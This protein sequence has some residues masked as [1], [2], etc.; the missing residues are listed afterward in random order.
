MDGRSLEPKAYLSRSLCPASLKHDGIGQGGCRGRCRPRPVYAILRSDLVVDDGSTDGTASLVA[1]FGSHR[2]RRIRLLK[3]TDRIKGYGGPAEWALKPPSIQSSLPSPMRIASSTWSDLEPL[4]GPGCRTPH[5]GWLPAKSA[6]LPAARGVSIP[7]ATI[8]LV[9]ALAGH[10]RTR[11]RLRALKVFRRDDVLSGLLPTTDGFF[12]NA[13]MLTRARTSRKST[14]AS[15]RCFHRPRLPAASAKSPSFEDSAHPHETDSFF[16]G[17][18]VLFP[19]NAAGRCQ[20]AARRSDG[21]IPGSSRRRPGGG[22]PGLFW[23]VG[24][25]FAGAR[26]IALCRDPA[27]DVGD[28]IAGDARTSWSALFRQ[29]AIA[30]LAGHGELQRLQSPRL[31]GS[32]RDEPGGPRHRACIYFLLGHLRVQQTHRIGSRG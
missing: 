24:V 13:E 27:P 30:L 2:I 6:G 4:A 12:V 29:T 32:A 28:R 18:E 1:Q 16:G 22:L 31:G 11:L 14:G 15:G 26:R 3:H 23:P 10:W 21:C 17:L 25:A 20:P 19:A 8:T 7:G 5:R 9:R